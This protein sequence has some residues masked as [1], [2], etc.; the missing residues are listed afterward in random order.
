[1]MTSGEWFVSF[2][3]DAAALILPPLPSISCETRNLS[4][5][6]T[7]EQLPDLPLSYMNSFCDILRKLSSFQASASL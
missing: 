2:L 3:T 4:I 7:A 6:D 5:L 1:M